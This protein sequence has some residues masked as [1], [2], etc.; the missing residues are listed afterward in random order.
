MATQARRNSAGLPYP[1]S[2][3]ENLFQKTL[4]DNRMLSR[5]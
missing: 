5:K 3:P 2:L 4:S 1:K